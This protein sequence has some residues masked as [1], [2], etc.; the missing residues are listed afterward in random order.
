MSL[1]LRSRNVLKKALASNFA[2]NEIANIMGGSKQIT[3][4]SVK[5]S[6]Q[7]E[8]KEI[9]Q[10]ICPAVVAANK[11]ISQLIC[12]AHTPGTENYDGSYF[13]I[14]D[15]VGSVA[16]W[17][18]VDDS[19][20]AAP[21][22]GADRAVEVTTVTSGMTAG[23][24]GTALYTAIVADSKFEAG[25]DDT[26]GTILVQQ[27]VA[28]VRIDIAA[29]TSPI[30]V[31]VDQQ[32]SDNYSET[33]F[34]LYDDAGSV[35]F[36]FDIDNAG[37]TIPAGAALAD[38]AVEITTV[39][40]GMTAGQAGT[41]IYTKIIADSEFEAGSDDT[42][43]TILVQS[44]TTG[45]K[46][47][48]DVGTSAIT[49]SVDQQG[50]DAAIDGAVIILKDAAGTVA[51]WVDVDN[52]GTVEPA[53]AAA[54]DRSIEITTVNSS[55]TAAQA[56]AVIYTAIDTDSEFDGVKDSGN[57]EILIQSADI[58]DG[59]G[60]SSSAIDAIQVADYQVGYTDGGSLSDSASYIL[61]I[62]LAKT[63]TDA[64]YLEIKSAIETGTG[65][66][67]SDEALRSLKILLSDYKAYTEIA[68]L[69]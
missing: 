36:W 3:K 67:L 60:Q 29:G 13:I 12:P 51:F 59:S 68:A 24:V 41:A 6:V 63:S 42:A 20:T 69:Y 34:L 14:Y 37:Q 58:I 61:R 35:A 26:A 57:G 23:Q 7:A 44:I 18:D 25:S 33:Y 38:R 1:S 31:S 15:E 56:A 40:T 17:F 2:G 50:V 9:S 28:G 62:A 8:V 5:Q 21:V 11:E 64:Y 46:S 66:S 47:D 22:H 4:I 32:G 45:V 49:V 10:L 30:A 39:N 54:A 65:T 16:F 53:I 19:G 43:G 48:I 27:T 52:A 55:M